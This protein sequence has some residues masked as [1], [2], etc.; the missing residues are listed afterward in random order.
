VFFSV[1]W[2]GALSQDALVAQ[3]NDRLMVAERLR[4]LVQLKQIELRDGVVH[5]RSNVMV[6]LAMPV[7]LWRRI[8]GWPR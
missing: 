5:L 4:R 8:L 7:F 6:V 2:T 3:Y 1:Y